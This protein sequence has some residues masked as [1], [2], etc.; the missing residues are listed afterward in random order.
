MAFIFLCLC[1]EKSTIFG[2]KFV[3]TTLQAKVLLL[4]EQGKFNSDIAYELGISYYNDSGLDETIQELQNYRKENSCISKID[5][6]YE[7]FTD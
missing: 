4:K 6:T 2:V 5:K 3:E 1:L 7:M